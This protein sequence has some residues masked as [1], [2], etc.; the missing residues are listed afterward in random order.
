MSDRLARVADIRSFPVKSLQAGGLPAADLTEAGVQGDRTWAVVDPDGAV[1][2][3][4]EDDR[5]RQVT[6][7]LDG[8]GVLVDVPGQ[9]QG[10]AGAAADEALSAFLDRPVRLQRS[11][12]R[13]LDVAAVH[14]VSSQSVD[15]ARTAAVQQAGYGHS[16]SGAEGDACPCSVE[17]PRANLVLDLDDAADPEVEWVGREVAVGEAVL[18]VTRAPKHCLGVYAEVLRP[19]RVAVDDPVRAT[20]DQG[21]SQR[22]A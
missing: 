15:A 7:H 17:E 21:E 19:G 4:R 16:H 12:A 13:Y 2:S 11:E 22:P 8:D 6:A 3:A 9:G 18:R 14:L 20:Q 1:V 10:L 5:L